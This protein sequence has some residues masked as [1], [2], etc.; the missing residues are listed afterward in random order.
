METPSIKKII[1]CSELDRVL[2]C[3]GSMTLSR[4]VSPRRGDEGQEGEAL[5]WIAHSKLRKEVAA[6]GDIGPCPVLPK[7]LSFS[8]WIADY[9]VSFIREVV[10]ADWSL[11]CEVPLSYE[12]DRFILSGHIDDCAMNADATEAIIFDLKTGRD[13]VDPADNNEQVFGYGCLLLRAYPTLRKITAY[14]VQPLNDEDEGYRRISEPMVLEG[15]V[16][17]RSLAV[18]ESRINAAL[19]NSMEVDDSPKACNWCPVA[20]QCP[21][22]IAR[23]E[24]MKLKL[25]DEA[26]ASIKETP[27]DAV[28]GSWVVAGRIISR[29]L[30]DAT[31]L[32]KERIATQGSITS[33]E[34]VV[35]TAKTGPGSYKYPQPAE[36]LKALRKRL[37]S[38]EELAPAISFSISR[39]RDAIAEK[40]GIPKT[41]KKGE[42]GD[43]IVAA[44]LKPLAEQGTRTVLQ[45][46]Q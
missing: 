40:L 44:E 27:D 9:Y 3:N 14:I 8:A 35:I 11:E 31:D 26:L 25:T 2:L 29:P 19:D 10:P 18:L 28:L 39:A 23:R 21:A 5:H 43:S 38:D 1:R 20:M 24:S 6:V 30:G 32:A 17:A 4:L 41:G 16:L 34:G 12:F 15:D 33:A 36:F 7:S 22:V 37:P 46:T 13:P 42:T 45:F